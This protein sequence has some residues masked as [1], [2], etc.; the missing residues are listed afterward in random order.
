MTSSTIHGFPRIGPRREVTAA[1]ESHWAGEV[2]AAELQATARDLRRQVWEG[3]RD[4]GLGQIP[5]N[6]FSLYD[7]VLDTIQLV[8]AVPERFRRD[9]DELAT[10][11]AMARGRAD[12]PAMEMTKWFDT[13]Y[14]YIVPE[15]GPDTAFRLE[16][17]PKPLAELAEAAALGIRTRPVLLGEPAFVQDR[18]GAE[19]AALDRAYRRLGGQGRRPK[20]LVASY[21]DHLGEALGVLAGT[22][23]DGLALDF[24][25]GGDR[26]LELLAATGGLGERTLVAGVVDGRN[27]WANDLERSLARLATLTGLAGEVV[28]SSSCSLQHVPL[29]LEAEPVLDPELRPWLAFAR[30]KVGELTTLARGLTEGTGAIAAELAANRQALA[31]RRRSTRVRDAA[32]RERL[33]GI[34]AGDL[35]RTSPYEVRQKAQRDRLASPPLPTT[36]IGSFP[37]TGEVRAARA[38]LRRGEI[39]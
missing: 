6:H 10:Y 27:V 26:N 23:V 21:F 32:V 2:S 22:P 34:G 36:T 28:A 20:L 39:D 33:E 13:N 11:F 38:A 3:L 4:A 31:S 18:T 14:H 29:D 17:E 1:T 25:R 9:D 19:L 24:T 35:R 12:A 15:L 16:A 37:Q 30:Q 5:S 7:H 8:G